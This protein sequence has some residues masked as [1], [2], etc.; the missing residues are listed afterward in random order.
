MK[1]KN[2]KKI[3]IITKIAKEEIRNKKKELNEE[4]INELKKLRKEVTDYISDIL[5]KPMLNKEKAEAIAKFTKQ[6]I[7]ENSLLKNKIVDEIINSK[8]TPIEIRQALEQKTKEIVGK[9]AIQGWLEYYWDWDLKAYKLIPLP[10]VDPVCILKDTKEIFLLDQPTKLLKGKPV[11]MVLRGIPFAIPMDFNI[12]EL[13]NTINELKEIDKR[14]IFGR[15]GLSSWDLYAKLK[16]PITDRIFKMKRITLG[17]ILSHV[18]ALVMGLM[19]MYILLSPY[20]F[21]AG[22]G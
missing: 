5:K 20:L 7:S 17:S 2:N 13:F 3:G 22:E 9:V 1:A 4:L 15:T 18:L 11:F 10:K 6:K 12:K 16:S 14:F 8:A 21:A 19:I